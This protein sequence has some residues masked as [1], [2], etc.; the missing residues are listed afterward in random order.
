MKSAVGILETSSKIRYGIDKRG[1][2]LYRFTP[3]YRYKNEC[4]IVVASK[5]VGQMIDYWVEIEYDEN[6]V[7]NGK[8]RGYIIAILGTVG[9][10][11]AELQAI[12][13]H[14]RSRSAYIRSLKSCENEIL[15]IVERERTLETHRHV[16]IEVSSIDPEGC[17][18]VD[19]AFSY[20]ADTG[21]L[22]IHIADVSY[23]IQPDTH[24]NLD[25]RARMF[26]ETLYEWSEGD[27][28]DTN[29]PIF[30]RILADDIMSLREGAVRPALSL[31]I[32][33]HPDTH[34]FTLLNERALVRTFVV[35]RHKATYEDYDPVAEGTA[36]LFK[37]F[38]V[39]VLGRV[40]S[41]TNHGIVEAMM[42]YYNKTVAEFM[43]RKGGAGLWREQDSIDETTLPAFVS[44][45]PYTPSLPASYTTIP[46]KKHDT[47]SREY[48]ITAYTHATSPIRRYADVIV[49]RIALSFTHIN[50][51]TLDTVVTELNALQRTHRKYYRD[52]AFARSLGTPPTNDFTIQ[53]KILTLQK[54]LERLGKYRLTC[55]IYPWNR[56]L[57]FSTYADGDVAERLERCFECRESVVFEYF[58]N[59]RRKLTVRLT[60][61][62]TYAKI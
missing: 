14:Y 40:P 5:M 43:L 22:G 15:E 52:M 55:Y 17:R 24:P 8:I 6:S 21:I 7:I 20:E 31:Y 16:A 39:Y 37:D 26:G 59:A 32:Q 56:I 44:L 48:D 27:T 61:S 10:P 38:C 51:E 25:S 36:E 57:S 28:G 49:Q 53:A 47:M 2:Y 19:D 42:I 23:W 29:S 4:V 3:Y 11:D 54:C 12:C 46:F 34:T 45:L 9:D 58:R 41:K 18:D 35:N 62:E 50:H 60:C 33:Y 1:H 30:P 13:R